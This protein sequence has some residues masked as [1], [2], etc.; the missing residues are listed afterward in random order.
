MKL[1]D[2]FRSSAAYRVRIALNF[3]GLSYEQIPVHLTRGGGEQK[4]PVYR[5]VNPQGLV[6]S[7]EIDGTVLNQSLA[8]I[9]Y[10][11]E[12][13]PDPPLLPGR[14]AK[15]ARVRAMALLIACDIHPINNLRVLQY[16]RN[17]L[18]QNDAAVDAWYRH[19]VEEGLN[20][21]E[22]L[23]SVGPHE[24]DFRRLPGTTDV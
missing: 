15:R 13:Q 16:L 23:V 7:L 8:I 20:A 5:A 2:Y 12:I 6:P 21:L 17:E 11:D 9:E 4:L 22:A 3:K 10:L 24:G 14:A 18:G 19:W 1:Y